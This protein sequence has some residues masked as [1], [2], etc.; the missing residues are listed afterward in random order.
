MWG[1]QRRGNFYRE[2][3]QKR[4]M[5]WELGLIPPGTRHLTSQVGNIHIID[6][7][8][9]W[10][11]LAGLNLLFTTRRKTISSKEKSNNSISEIISFYNS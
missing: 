10:Q 6:N 2:V 7:E 11:L 5:C 4:L 3:F 8:A 9:S 1:A